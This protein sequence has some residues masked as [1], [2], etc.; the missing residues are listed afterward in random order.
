M[1]K[2]TAL[3]IHHLPNQTFVR[4]LNREISLSFTNQLFFRPF[5]EIVCKRAH[6][7]RITI[8]KC[9][10]WDLA[11]FVK[12]S[13]KK[14]RFRKTLFYSLA[15]TRLIMTG[16]G[17]LIDRSTP[18]LI[19]ANSMVVHEIPAILFSVHRRN[20]KAQLYFCF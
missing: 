1:E 5:L 15:R 8:C 19:L 12:I 6:P 13:G 10:F 2:N 14:N 18:G 16:S 3:V 9:S 20:L 11:S 7:D 4:L 17:L